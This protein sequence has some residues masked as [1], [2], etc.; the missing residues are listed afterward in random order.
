[1][2]GP[3]EMPI[4]DLLERNAKLYGNEVALVEINP[5]LQEKRRIT[6]KEYD[7][8]MPAPTTAY[9][10]E[11][12]WQV[13]D[14]KANR[15]ANMLMA[16]GI[17]RGNK[18][19]IL[20]MNCLEF[21]PI[22]FGI[23][24]TGAVVVPM[25]FRFS[26]DEIKYCLELSETDVLMFGP[27]F[28]G[29]VEEIAEDIGDNRLL[30]YVGTGVCPTFAEDYDEQVVNFS[31]LAPAVHL[32]NADDAAIYFSSGTTGFPK[33]ILHN[34]ESLSHS[35]CV[36]QNHHSTTHDDCFLLIPPLYHTGAKMH[37]FG[38]LMTGSKAV[39][40]K[41]TSPKAILEAISQERCTIVWL[42]VPWAQDLLDALDRGDLKL[43]DYHTDQL[44]LM[45]IGAQPV[46]PVLVRRWLRYFPNN[47]Y[48][49]NYG[50]SESIGPGCVHL[51][52]ENIHKV[53]AIGVPG[54]G[55]QCRIVEEDGVTEVRQ[56][57]VGELCV[58]GP[59]VMTCYYNDPKATA[60]VLMPDGWLRT[61]DMAMQD[62]DGFIFLV[63]RKKDVIISG[64]E[65]IYPVQIEDFLRTNNAV[66]DVAVIGLPDPRLGE[67]TGAI[68]EVKEGY[69]LTEEEVNKFCGE[70]P[71]YKRPRKIIF[72]SIP[73]NATGK[74]EKPKLRE[75]YCV[76]NLVA[77]Q[78]GIEL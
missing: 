13:F 32:T 68:I 50:L 4:T 3:I 2:K 66:K 29:R 56:G 31:S 25:N 40:L 62:E 20:L 60:E 41:G 18:V 65:N 73:R 59:G 39:L 24:K 48:D 34:H 28:I 75:I 19:A 17:G 36:E 9:R 77:A 49:T 10:R 44:R 21:L 55:W 37:W 16:R 33:A 71:R 42:L 47:Q 78:N 58:K 12:T 6:W 35:A 74:I 5:E 53:G 54:Y 46:P 45:H 30:L 38:S 64:G 15:V 7:L 27:E 76:E 26:A 70:L 14:E 57:S 8:I 69:S 1:M 52:V 43:S 61:G 67:I 23:L 51:G 11:I 22:Y 63:D 72:A